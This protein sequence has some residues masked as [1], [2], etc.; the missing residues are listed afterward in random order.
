MINDHHI[1]VFSR[2][3]GTAGNPHRLIFLD[4][5]LNVQLIDQNPQEDEENASNLEKDP[6]IHHQSRFLLAPF[7]RPMGQ[8]HK[9]PSRQKIIKQKVNF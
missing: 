9:G 5:H 2:E 1:G 3:G 8:F 6:L 7:F 4:A